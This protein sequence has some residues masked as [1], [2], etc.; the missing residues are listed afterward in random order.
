[1]LDDL[2]PT[3]DDAATVLMA[4]LGYRAR[5]ITRFPMGLAHYVYD[6]ETDRGEKV[7]VR[8]TR[9]TQAAA[10]RGAVIWSAR[11]R[12][13]GVPLPKLLYTDTEGISNRFPVLI[14]ERL[15]GSDLGLVYGSLSSLE[16]REL[17]ARMVEIQQRVARLPAGRGFGYGADAADPHLQPTWRMVLDQHLERSRSRIRAVGL[18]DPAVVDRVAARLNAHASAFDGVRP[19]C[20]LDDTTTKNVLIDR[21]Q[22]S[23]IVDVDT[24][25]YGDLLRTVALTRMSLL[26]SQD[27]TVY[28]DA[29]A[30]LLDLSAE[31]VRLLDLYTAMF[32][33]DF[34]SE[35]GQVFNRSRPL[36]STDEQAR[37][38][39][40]IVDELLDD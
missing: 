12:G 11:L 34:L 37:R 18:V 19:V 21:G 2:A 6:V 28:T 40:S 15:P 1:V 17:A 14:M 33:V 24:V 20:F 38:L 8:L 13:L 10:F 39:I 30:T 25:C 7:V 35:I 4:A 29:W 3:P 9:R 5:R 27:D 16:K 23:G 36:A 22:L 32:G 31:Q 26:A